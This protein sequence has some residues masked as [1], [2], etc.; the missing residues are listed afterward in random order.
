MGKRKGTSVARW[1]GGLGVLVVAG[2]GGSEVTATLTPEAVRLEA[3]SALQQ[4]GPAG[5]AANYPPAV[6]AL[7]ATGAPV[8]GV[9]VEFA[10][11]SSFTPVS[12]L[13]GEDGMA[14]VVSWQ[15]PPGP[16][17]LRA[18]ALGLESVSFA[19]EG[20]PR[21]FDLE[22]RWLATPP[23]E[24]ADAVEQAEA[25][26]EGIIWEDLPDEELADTPVCARGGGE[27][28]AT[29]NETVDDVVI[30]TAVETMDG[31]GNAGAQGYPCLIR[32]PGTQT[33]VGFVRF[34]SDDVAL[35][36]ADLRL[37][38]ALHEMIH[39]LG[40]VPGLFNVRTPSGFTRTCLALPSTGAPSTLV[41][42]THFSCPHAREAFDRIGGA[43][44]AGNKVPLENGATVALTANTL[45]HHWRK[46][47]FKEELMTGWFTAGVPAPLSLAT[48]G[49]LADLDYS[50]SYAGAQ[51]FGFSGTIA[52]VP[53]SAPGVGF[54]V[55]EPESPA[56][57]VHGIRHE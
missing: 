40:F 53:A 49:A 17:E 47:S 11:G 43:A 24:M 52:T 34:D 30:L 33:I 5:E 3:T 29:L 7:D 14:K 45:N 10:S 22:I 55:V 27:A 12:A 21:S 41:Q 46:T 38:F 16:G 23:P 54:R 15:L 56:P 19:A 35:L 32:D 25:I 51:P 36:D 13:T 39:A 18:T 50:V 31:P 20:L 28:P 4:R 57:M 9:R 37:G 2:C 26:L 1:G 48:V 42:D 8:A 6:R 44:Y